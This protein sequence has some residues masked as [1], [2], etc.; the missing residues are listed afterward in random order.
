M[1]K[2]SKAKHAQHAVDAFARNEHAAEVSPEVTPGNGGVDSE[3][4]KPSLKP[5]RRPSFHQHLNEVVEA[6]IYE[7]FVDVHRLILKKPAASRNANELAVVSRALGQL[8]RFK[9]LS[10]AK[11]LEL[12]QAAVLIR[13]A[14]DEVLLY[15]TERPL[16]AYLV[17]TG[18]MSALKFYKGCDAL[19]SQVVELR[20]RNRVAHNLADD[21]N[22]QK[23]KS[24]VKK[25]LSHRRDTM[26]QDSVDVGELARAEQMVFG[27]SSRKEVLPAK[28]VAAMSDAELQRAMRK[29][30]QIVHLSSDDRHR[31]FADRKP[32]ELKR[33]DDAAALAKLRAARRGA[34]DGR[35][36]RTLGNIASRTARRGMECGGADAGMAG[37]ADRKAADTAAD[38][39]S[40]EA[41]E[42]LDELDGN[43]AMFSIKHQYPPG[44]EI[45]ASA[46]ITDTP[47]VV[48][49]VSNSSVWLLAFE[50]LVYQSVLMD[51][52]TVYQ[53]CALLTSKHWT[54]KQMTQPELRN[55]VKHLKK[56]TYHPRE[57]ILKYGMANDALLIVG[58]GRCGMMSKLQVPST[59]QQ[60]RQDS[61]EPDTTDVLVPIKL[62]C[63]P[64]TEPKL[65]DA[66]DSNFD[67]RAALAT[68]E[69]H[70]TGGAI[71]SMELC[72]LDEGDIFDD[73]SAWR[74]RAGYNRGMECEL[75]ALSDCIVLS[76]T[77]EDL[78]KK[79]PALSKNL[80]HASSERRNFHTARLCDVKAALLSPP[81][82]QESPRWSDFKIAP[83][84]QYHTR[85]AWSRHSRKMSSMSDHMNHVHR[86][87]KNTAQLP[88]R[89]L[90]SLK[91]STMPRS[92]WND[93]NILEPS[94]FHPLDMRAET[95]SH[96]WNSTRFKR[97]G[98]GLTVQSNTLTSQQT[99][100][101]NALALNSTFDHTWS[102][103]HFGENSSMA[104]NS[105]NNDG[106]CASNR[107][108]K[109]DVS[110][111]ATE[112]YTTF[113]DLRR[114]C[115]R[116]K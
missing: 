95:L 71:V 114:R 68:A 32:S 78:H 56:R 33:D 89:L 86:N 29:M 111:L 62:L 90:E 92:S 17:L 77:A 110:Q 96:T 4:T 60:A 40:Y 116:Q 47:H 12:A 109:G 38:G 9:Q 42:G 69:Q 20:V 101:T 10:P 99:L 105:G 44:S 28:A 107:R 26:R 39:G 24:G 19:I 61:A 27:G 76:M 91:S 7:E 104:L 81:I 100:N 15:Q 57:H 35:S 59:L 98:E 22:R 82:Q 14:P 5:Q 66:V 108:N 93:A 65:P 46:V 21:Q 11:L 58:S 51:S 8:P 54:F 43:R 37:S 80:E 84:Q 94:R 52:D 63:A 113:R 6:T 2:W 36:K 72:Q 1:S 70:S 112:Q 3:E 103:E 45:G 41:G 55:F 67:I 85:K 74:C 88:K 13:L 97:C 25:A 102:S 18:S 87:M 75:V 79:F 34:S 50:K 53:I 48:S 30:E 23:W 16:F 49:V 73:I 115:A 31:G 64:H 83:P 106:R